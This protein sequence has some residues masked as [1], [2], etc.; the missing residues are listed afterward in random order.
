MAL[1]ATLEFGDKNIKRYPKRYLIADYHLVFN[2]EYNAFA[3]EEAARCERLELVVIAPGKDDL[4]LFEWFTTQGVQ[5]GRI[6]ISQGYDSSTNNEDRQVIYFEVGR[7]FSLSE[8]YDID[9]QRRRLVKLAITAENIE[10]D[11][12]TYICK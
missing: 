3:P 11:G 1:T 8:M 10:I 7:C 12:I 5:D 2:R 9:N 6:I 4:T